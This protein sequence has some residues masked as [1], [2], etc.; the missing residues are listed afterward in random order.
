METVKKIKLHSLT[1]NKKCP[2]MTQRLKA[3]PKPFSVQ[4][5]LLV[6]LPTTIPISTKLSIELDDNIDCGKIVGFLSLS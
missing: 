2:R 1:G 4:N 6:C 5:K 3:E